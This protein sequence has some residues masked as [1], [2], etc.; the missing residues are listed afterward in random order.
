[1][2][3]SPNLAVRSM[4]APRAGENECAENLRKSGLSIGEEP[5]EP[6]WKC[7]MNMSDNAR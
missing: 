5:L 3:V 7:E 4:R 1:M 6:I 2:A